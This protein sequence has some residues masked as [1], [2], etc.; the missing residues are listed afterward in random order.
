MRH[1]ASCFRPWPAAAVLALLAGWPRPA[2]AEPPAGWVPVDAATLA[3]ARGGDPGLPALA[4][5][6]DLTRAVSLNGNEVAHASLHLGAGTVQAAGA[7]ALIQNGPGNVALAALPASALA[8]FVIQ[9]ALDGQWIRNQT[10]VNATVTN[11][12]L[13]SALHAQASLADALAGAL[14][15]R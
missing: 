9:N 5:Q 3:D 10:V 15:P 12:S 4:V 11:L 8:P 14:R 7:A 2:A 13:F 6:V 1:P